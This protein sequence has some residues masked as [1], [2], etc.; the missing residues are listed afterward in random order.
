MNQEKIG[1]ILMNRRQFM[2]KIINE[3]KHIVKEHKKVATAVVIIF[4]ILLIF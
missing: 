2:E 3:A 4:L 1:E